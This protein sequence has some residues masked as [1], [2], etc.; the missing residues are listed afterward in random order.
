MMFTGCYSE[1]KE[2]NIKNTINNENKSVSPS[3]QSQTKELPKALNEP[4]K[5]NQYVFDNGTKNVPST[6]AEF[7]AF[8]NEQKQK[9]NW[10]WDEVNEDTNTGL[11]STN[12]ISNDNSFFGKWKIKKLSFVDDTGYLNYFELRTPNPSYLDNVVGSKIYIDDNAIKL[13][14]KIVLRRPK[15]RVYTKNMLPPKYGSSVTLSINN[16]YLNSCLSKQNNYLS[17]LYCFVEKDDYL[18]MIL[19][20]GKDKNGLGEDRILGNVYTLVRQR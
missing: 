8:S 15:F 1:Y 11:I 13:N 19:Y 16:S 9:E 5:G 20:A 4:K 2:T 14:G 6:E 3:N 18:L 12:T 17:L 10:N 7:D